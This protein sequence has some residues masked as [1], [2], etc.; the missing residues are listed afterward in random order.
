MDNQQVT[1]FRV[2]WLIG[3]LE[4]E[5]CFSLGW[6][7]T[8]TN[9]PS[10]RSMISMSSSDFELCWK[11]GSILDD[12]GVGKLFVR[13]RH[14]NKKDQLEVAVIG[15]KRCK[16][17]L[18]QIVPFMT[19]SRKKRAAETL[20]EFINRRFSLPKT[21]PYTKEDVIFGERMRALNGYHLRQNFRDLTRDT[22]GK[23]GEGKVQSN[24]ESVGVN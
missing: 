19:D 23:S 4:G 15:L 24:N 17:L 5:G 2:G 18:D 3:F 21:T 6:V 7:N 11:A 20:L 12:L 13:V 22:L 10:M 1:P 9:N 16:T 14:T 8:N